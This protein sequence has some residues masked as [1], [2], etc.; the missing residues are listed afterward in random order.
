MKIEND[1]FIAPEP[2]ELE[3]LEEVWKILKAHDKVSDNHLVS[4]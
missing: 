2:Q 1:I 4:Q 3:D